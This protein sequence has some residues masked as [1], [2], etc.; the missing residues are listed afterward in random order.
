MAERNKG[1]NNTW[2]S[3]SGVKGVIEKKSDHNMRSHVL[4]LSCKIVIRFFY[5]TLLL[6]GALISTNYSS[7]FMRS[8]AFPG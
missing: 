8:R 2:S 4:A 1:L 3:K 7:F 6:S 5:G